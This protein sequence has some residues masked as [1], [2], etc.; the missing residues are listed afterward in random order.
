M[1]CLLGQ[2]TFPSAAAAA[3]KSAK[4]APVKQAG[5]EEGMEETQPVKVAPIIII[6]PADKAEKTLSGK[7]QFFLGTTHSHSIYSGDLAKGVATKKYNGVAN[8]SVQTP[9]DVLAIARTNFYDFYFITDHSSPEQTEYYKGGFTDEHWAATLKFAQAATTP[10]FLALRGYE[11][12]RNND[13]DQ[14]GLGHMNVLNSAAWNSAYAAG[15]TFP[16]LYDWMA[17]QAKAFVVAQFNHPAL[18]GGKAKNFMNYAGRTKARNEAVRLAEIWNS[19]E[20]MKY[21]PVVQKIWALGWKVAPSA[22]TDVHGVFGIENRHIRTGILAER[23]TQEAVMEALQARRVYASV[24]PELH[25]EFTLND[26]EMGT[27]LAARPTG[28]LTAK[29]F[30]NDLTGVAMSKVEIYGA[31]YEAN[32]GGTQTLATLSLAKDQKTASGRVPDGYDFYYAA[33]FKEGVDTARAFSAPIW[34]DDN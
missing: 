33:A 31:K 6:K 26:I 9:A 22:G 13:P 15:H 17:P 7:Y 30:V 24:E 23:L 5:G 3:K 11:F 34:M 12:S 14:G 1:L 10:D 2:F 32:G 19:G 29:V 28:E 20:S 21:V 25:F 27:S 4:K 8:Y 18:P 16:W